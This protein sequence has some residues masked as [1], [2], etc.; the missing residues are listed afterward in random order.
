MLKPWHRRSI[1]LSTRGG[2][3]HTTT[4][5]TLK[6]HIFDH[7][8]ARYAVSKFCCRL[9]P[10]DL[11]IFSKI[12]DQV[13]LIENAVELQ[14]YFDR[15]AANKVPGR[16]LYVGRLAANKGVGRLLHAVAVASRTVPLQLHLV[17]ADT[18]CQRPQLERMARSLGIS[19]MVSF[20]GEVGSEELLEEFELADI[21]VSAAQYEG[22][23]ISAIEARAAGCR[24]LLQRNDAFVSTFGGDTCAT[25]VDF[26][27]S[28]MAGQIL[29][30]V[31]GSSRKTASATRHI[32][33]RFSW[34]TQFPRWAEVY[35]KLRDG[36]AAHQK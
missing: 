3:F 32:V 10:G 11:A 31:V 4:L 19:K 34:D 29:A 22:F 9:Q 5:S 8:V 14:R 13:H 25:F 2:I 28:E 18:D 6:R 36:S 30:D 7:L 17:G 27:D 21:F 12:S 16:C 35:S 1:V 15:S 24:M 33:D 20:R 23:G 26:A